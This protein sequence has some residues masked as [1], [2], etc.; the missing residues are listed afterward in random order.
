MTLQTTLPWLK[1]VTRKHSAVIAAAIII[2]LGIFLRTYHFSDWLHFE[3]DQVYDIETISPAITGGIGHLP[4]VGTNVGGGDL[5]LGPAFYYLEY[6]SALLFGNTPAGHATLVLIL[7]ILSMPLFF[8]VARRYFS[9]RESVGLLAIFTF[10]LFSILYSRF[11]WSPNVLPF[12]MLLL[13]YCMLRSVSPK[14]PHPARWFLSAVAVMAIATHIHLN[15]L[16]T[17]P[18]IFV[19]FYA[20]KHPRFGWKAWLAA[21]VIVV[22]ITS[23]LIIND[24][25]TNGE[26]FNLLQIKL[27]KT[28]AHIGAPQ[29]IIAQDIA[30]NA[31]EYFFI[32]SGNDQINGIKLSGYGFPEGS[33]D[34]LPTKLFSIILFIAAGT[35]FLRAYLKEKDD[36]RKSF[37]L[38]MGIWLISSFALFYTIAQGYRMYPR[39]FL[40]VSPL[41]IIWFGFLVRALSPEKNR[42]RL[43]VFVTVILIAVGSNLLATKQYF[44]QL[45][46]NSFSHIPTG[47]VFPDTHRARLDDQLAVVDY[48]ASKTK[49]NGYPVY[50]KSY[51]EIEPSLWYHLN[52]RGVSYRGDIDPKRVYAEGNY[53]TINSNP[54]SRNADPTFTIAE[55][56]QFGIFTVNYLA[57]LPQAVTALRESPSDFK[58]Y[59]MTSE[60]S[61][62]MTWDKVFSK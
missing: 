42:I 20:I 30:Y 36:D 19:L 25:A 23:P 4:L 46:E 15:S 17:V 35:F 43:A 26:N 55:T 16:F 9:D 57:P 56:R 47:D 29:H 53:F 37:L 28:K 2:A 12:L 60:L 3:I 50:L 40:I 38:L 44:D 7:S 33:N 41:S 54:N 22:L 27:N 48:I 51:Q 18:L 1:K 45:R 62:L 13:S 52:Q 59:F 21:A 34:S 5:R 6:L 14:E 31:Y 61:Q 24:I 10:S 49:G 32:L 11:S 8:V 39:F 58:P